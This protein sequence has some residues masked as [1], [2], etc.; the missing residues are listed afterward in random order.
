MLKE[1][2]SIKNKAHNAVRSVSIRETPQDEPPSTL[3]IVCEE[4]VV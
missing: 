1:N 4:T 3:I 2:L